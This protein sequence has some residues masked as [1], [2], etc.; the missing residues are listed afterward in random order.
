MSDELFVRV[1]LED[2]DDC[3]E[4]VRECAIPPVYPVIPDCGFM[5]S[6]ELRNMTECRVWKDR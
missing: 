5:V 4:Y 6:H 1:K 2:I 3:D